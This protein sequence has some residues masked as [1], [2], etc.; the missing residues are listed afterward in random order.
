MPVCANCGNP[1]KFGRVVQ[2][3]FHD[4]GK[5]CDV[6]W[7]FCSEGCWGDWVKKMEALKRIRSVKEIINPSYRIR[8]HTHKDWNYHD[9]HRFFLSCRDSKKHFCRGIIKKKSDIIFSSNNYIFCPKC[10]YTVQIDME[11]EVKSYV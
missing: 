11:T 10:G 5:Y 4:N 7:Y 6:E 2:Y 8:F 3:S 1:K 9:S